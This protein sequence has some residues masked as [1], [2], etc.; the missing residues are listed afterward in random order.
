MTQP[1]P[2]PGKDNVADRALL[3]FVR[4]HQRQV[5]K[6]LQTYGTPLQTFNGRS[7]LGDAMEELCDAWQFVQQAKMEQ[8]E[9]REKAEKLIAAIQ[10]VEITTITDRANT[11]TEEEW[12][13]WRRV[14]GTADQ[15]R[16][17]LDGQ[18][19]ER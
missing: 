2:K 15:L 5:A 7:A 12:S 10:V 16:E 6:G 11:W 4:V 18:G 17:A 1:A 14:D 3:D 9:I 8:A 19:E 13:R